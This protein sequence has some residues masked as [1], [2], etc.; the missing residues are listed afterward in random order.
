M[1][2]IEAEVLQIY[3]VGGADAGGAGHQEDSLVVH[4]LLKS[5][6][7]L[8]LLDLVVPRR[9]RDLLVLVLNPH[10]EILVIRQVPD[11][12]LA[13]PL[14]SG[15]HEIYKALT[16]IVDHLNIVVDAVT[17][18]ERQD[19]VDIDGQSLEF[20]RVAKHPLAYFVVINVLEIVDGSPRTTRESL[21]CILNIKTHV[22]YELILAL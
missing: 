14:G 21:I 17:L 4:L 9:H 7:V 11:P 19:V 22:C 1:H 5:H 20:I 2:V 6:A 10:K 13:A 15:F 8:Q 12:A 16:V 3:V 18:L